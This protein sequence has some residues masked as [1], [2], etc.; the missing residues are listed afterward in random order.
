MPEYGDKE[1]ELVVMIDVLKSELF[2]IEI[3]LQNALKQAREKCF[4]IVKQLITKM[5]GLSEELFKDVLV[6][7]GLFYEKLKDECE[8]EKQMFLNRIETEEQEIVLSDYA[9][10]ARESIV[11]LMISEDREVLSE[12]LT[13]FKEQID[14]KI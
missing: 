11:D 7:T 13:H 9:E 3:N 6:E 8:K 14:A 10:E 1:N 12:L 2:D 4:S 5:G